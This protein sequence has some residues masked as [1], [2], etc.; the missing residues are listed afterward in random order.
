MS[1]LDFDPETLSTVIR[2]K[3]FLAL[4]RAAVDVDTIRT[5]D[6]RLLR[7]LRLLV[8]IDLQALVVPAGDDEP[9]VRLPLLLAGKGGDA[10][11]PDAA[12]PEPFDPGTPR[13]PGVHLHWAV[14]DALLR[15]RLEE[16]PAASAN[17][18]GLQALPDRWVVLRILLPRNAREAAVR[19]WVLEADRAVAVPLEEWSEG[20][21]ASRAAEP[22]GVAVAPDDL[23]GTVGGSV[24]WAAV[25]DAV[26]N[27]FAFH[28]PLDDLAAAASGGVDGNAASYVVAGWWSRPGADPLDA[29]RSAASFAELLDG[30]R[31]RLLDEAGDARTSQ[32]RRSSR[33]ELRKALGLETADRFGEARTGAAALR[34]PRAAAT[35]PA[36]SPID[37]TI[38][39][40]TVV[41]ASSKFAAGAIDRYVTEPWHLRSSL[42]HGAVYGVPVS[43]P[44]PVDTRP[45]S[46]ALRVAIGRHDDDVVG[47]LASVPGAPASARADTERVLAAFTA[48]KLSR[49]GSAEG[50]VEVEEHR[51]D[52]AFASLP[53]GTAGTDRFLSGGREG[54]QVA[55]RRARRPTTIDKGVEKVAHGSTLDATLVFSKRQYDLV[56]ASESHVHEVMQA[57]EEDVVLP[58][59][60]RVVAR[61]APRFAFP[62]DPLVGVQGARRS[63]RHG[64]DGR[65]SPDGKLTCRWP[66]Q[67]I[68]EVQG[69]V[70]GDRLVRSLGSGAIPEEVVLLAREAVLHDPYH[71]AWLAAASVGSGRPSTPVA[72]RLAAEA[73]IRFG[74]DGTYDGTTAA[75]APKAGSFE[76]RWVADE[77]RRFSLVKGV[78]PDPVGV[79][80]WSQPW[81][82]LW[83]E[84]EVE[85]ETPADPSLG[86]WAL[87]DV[88]LERDDAELP[89]PSPHAVQG[90]SLLTTGAAT[91][92]RAAVLDWLAAEDA[93]ESGGGIGEADEATEDALRRLAQA[94]AEVDL[95]TATLDGL[96]HRLL[97]LPARDGLRRAVDGD[98][99]IAPPA[100]V[101]APTL[102]V[103]DRLRLTRARLVDAFGRLLDVP[104][105][106]ASTAVVGAVEGDPGALRLRPR[107]TRPSRWRFHF[108]DAAAPAAAPD[109]AEARVDQVDPT[110]TVNPV[111][112]FLLPDHLD[113]SLEVFGVDGQPLGELL[114]EAVGGT[115]VWEIAAGREGPPD[116]GPSYGLAPVQQS[117]GWL[118]A[119]VVAADAAAR[120]A[121]EPPRES[122]LSALLR[123]IDTT[124]WTVDTF[125]LLGGEHVAGLV[126]RPIAVARARLRLEL[127]PEDDLDLSDPARAA[128]RAAAEE[129]LAAV[130][131]PVRIGELTRTDDGV[132][133]F[134]VDDDYSRF[135]LVDKAVAAFAPE[136]GRSRGQLGLLGES[137][138]LPDTAAITHPYVVGT[139]EGDT[140]HLHVGQTV[141]LTL[142]MHPAGKAHLTSG[143]LPRKALALAR[144]WVGP[145]LAAMA[146]SLRTGPVLVE[147]DL[148]P[149]QQVRLPKVS[150]FGQNQAFL[151]RDTPATWRTDAILA[152]TQTALLP[153]TPAAFREGWVRV[154]P[155]PAEGGGE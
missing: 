150:V 30:L 73:A 57:A 52:A 111:A 9:M 14:P 41:A 126:G 122:A 114:H 115:V 94:V 105:D 124:L 113:E 103:G 67:V 89:A 31:W 86:G 22:A 56:L 51:H 129:A 101:G 20:S 47:A 90:R 121:P 149:E 99:G 116:A 42:L 95:V 75:L 65:A 38:A 1:G 39:R 66:T 26:L 119:G 133:G 45:A 117:L 153:D 82:P 112:G 63:L 12:M 48:Q 144:D 68:G 107:L 11:D 98:G 97:G 10:S 145:G 132:L 80:A 83:L 139:G 123:A 135:R 61:P 60:P 13:P 5:W 77:L 29:A 36:F 37:E 100:P 17:R 131:F 91:T 50:A 54:T 78:D 69:V 138:P 143:I 76:R 118:A 87:G 81:V 152:A 64:R 74:R 44:T 130:A 151:W 21:A 88:D 28:D 79:T 146:P 40:R 93:R 24:T 33:S 34:A 49:L 108:V 106:G 142:L 23:T 19:G 110:L 140:I 32:L 154:V 43:G 141:T 59:E 27:R 96:R 3:R 2:S 8:P 84:W 16:R 104:V 62:T 6:D 125:A 120:T 128:E 7:D 71:V 137:G 58:A 72:R 85:V 134:F 147:T 46:E 55:T 18:L 4:D 148:D 35:S 15:G 25:Y 136:S 92:L 102:L 127:R 53:G 70:S 155:E 109:A